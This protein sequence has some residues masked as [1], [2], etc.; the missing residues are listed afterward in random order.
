MKKSECGDVLP[1]PVLE[2]LLGMIG[3]G[4]VACV[5]RAAAVNFTTKQ[6]RTNSTQRET[7]Q[8]AKQ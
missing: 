7:P 3:V 2:A 4:N 5:L 1:V 6:P 8:R